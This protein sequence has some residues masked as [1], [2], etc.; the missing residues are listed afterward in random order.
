MN[1]K[2]TTGILAREDSN[3]DWSRGSEDEQKLTDWT[4]YQ[5]NGSL[6]DSNWEK[7]GKSDSEIKGITENVYRFLDLLTVL[8]SGA[9][10]YHEKD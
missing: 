8:N 2:I 3:R 4:G 5:S 9:I 6:K 7:E 1:F 10:Y